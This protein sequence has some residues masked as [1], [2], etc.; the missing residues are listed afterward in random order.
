[1][2]PRITVA[3]RGLFADFGGGQPVDGGLVRLGP[4]E[5]PLG[6]GFS[7]HFKFIMGSML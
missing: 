5:I 2:D 4:P 6:A 7:L 1:M 3:F